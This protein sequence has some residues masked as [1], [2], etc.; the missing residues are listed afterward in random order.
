MK[1]ILLIILAMLLIVSGCGEREANDVSEEYEQRV[2]HEE[3]TIPGVDEVVYR[4]VTLGFALA[5]KQDWQIQESIERQNDKQMVLLTV[6]K[7]DRKLDIRA[8]NAGWSG[9]MPLVRL[10]QRARDTQT[11]VEA[12]G[13]PGIRTHLQRFDEDYV[14]IEQNNIVYEFTGKPE[15]VDAILEE[16]VLFE[17][18]KI[19]PEQILVNR[20]QKDDLPQAVRRWI[21]N[22]MKLDMV[23]MAE[24]M[25]YDDKF[26]IF[27]TWGTRPTGG[28]EVKIQNAVF[29]DETIYVQLDFTSPG[30][31]EMV[32]QAFTHPYD[33]AGIDD[34]DK[35]IQFERYRPDEPR[36]LAGIEGIDTLPEIQAESRSIKLFSPVPD[37]EVSDPVKVTGIA[38][39][40]EANVEY[41]VLDESGDVVDRGFTTATAAYTWGYYEFEFSVR[42]HFESGDTFILELF[43]TDMKDGERRDI[44]SVP[45]RLQ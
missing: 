4:N 16:L 23:P 1:I 11:D 15:I 42:D 2:D 3:G 25:R 6:T 18:E 44:V 13:A 41:R 45:L 17:P 5:G 10:D 34:P 7:D 30:P 20:L 19:D 24:S 40:H 8:V 37:T 31:D 32:T 43:Y 14:R 27:A 26:Y 9:L 33:I 28:Y 29:R 35:P 22:L 38:N 36:T 12:G 21:D 39:V